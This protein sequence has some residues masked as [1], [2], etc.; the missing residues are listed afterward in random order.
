MKKYVGLVVVLLFFVGIDVVRPGDVISLACPR[1]VKRAQVRAGRAQPVGKPVDVAHKKPLLV[2]KRHRVDLKKSLR[3]VSPA[4]STDASIDDEDVS[5][6]PASFEGYADEVEQYEA[7]LKK[8][9]EMTR[10]QQLQNSFL[11]RKLCSQ[12]DEQIA[13][14]QPEN[15]NN[16]A[17]P[18]DYKNMYF[19]NLLILQLKKDLNSCLLKILRT[20]G[21]WNSLQQSI[22]ETKEETERTQQK[23]FEFDR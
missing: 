3:P 7:Q 2:V 10:E 17:T 22:I 20:I 5:A 19:H 21:E 8:N 15:F 16:F 9:R 12:I 1:R 11:V 6:V 18:A 14:G 13:K 4:T 23:I